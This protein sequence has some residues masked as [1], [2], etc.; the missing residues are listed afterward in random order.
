MVTRPCARARG[1]GGKGYLLPG[2][3]AVAH[4]L[5]GREEDQ[6]AVGY[7]PQQPGCK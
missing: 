4:D 7:V 1:G 6:H 5:V 3:D 2:R